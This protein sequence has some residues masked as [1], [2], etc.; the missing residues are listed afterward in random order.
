MI[1]LG[2]SSELVGRRVRVR[3]LD[4]RTCVEAPHVD[5]EDGRAGVAI[6]IVAILGGTGDSPHHVL[7]RF[8]EWVRWSTAIGDRV[9]TTQLSERLYAV[10]ELVALD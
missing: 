9:V 2:D 6:A 7:V 8:D 4:G 3:L 5:A 1:R 10:D